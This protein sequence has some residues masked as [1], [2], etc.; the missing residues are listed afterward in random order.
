MSATHDGFSCE[1][2][3]SEIARLRSRLSMAERVVEAARDL[4]ATDPDYEEHGVL[5]VDDGPFMAL[6][7]RLA[8]WEGK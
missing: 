4:V 8:E 5:R 2:A 1:E 7:A 3:E 6:R